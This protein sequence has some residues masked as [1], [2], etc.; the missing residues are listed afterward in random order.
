MYLVTALLILVEAG[1][2]QRTPGPR[3]LAEILR[4]HRHPRAAGDA[5][6]P[7]HLHTV[8]GPDR[9]HAALFMEAGDPVDAEGAAFGFL[10]G[11]LACCPET[12]GW[13]LAALGRV[14]P[15]GTEEPRSQGVTCQGNDPPCP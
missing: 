5:T 3:E 15:A 7:A 2:S 8:A 14:Q 11:A 13:A 10:A 1:R 6:V 12:V 4:S 9:V